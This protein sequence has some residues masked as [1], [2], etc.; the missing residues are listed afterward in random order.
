ML[1]A[2]A[3]FIIGQPVRHRLFG[4]RGVI[5]DVDPRFANTEEWYQSIPADVRPSK[6]QPFYHLFAE[7]PDKSPYIA[8][9]S[10]QNLVPDSEEG[11]D[12][13]GHPDF[14]EIFGDLENGRYVPREQMN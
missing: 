9:V 7:S 13:I 4:F 2:K 3:K 12:P 5:F 6:D 11:T 10:E 14:D 1:K 8:Y